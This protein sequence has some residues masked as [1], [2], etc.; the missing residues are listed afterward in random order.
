MVSRPL[1]PGPAAPSRTSA[2]Y[3]DTSAATKLVLAEAESA[4]LRAWCDRSRSTGGRIVISDL[5][6][7]ELL[8][9]V[10]RHDPDLLPLADRTAAR[11]DRLRLT[12]DDFDRA[13]AIE[14]PALRTLDALHLAAALQLGAALA[15]VVTYG[16][17]LAEAADLRGVARTA[18][19]RDR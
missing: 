10:G 11:F 17:R 13:T 2:W 19:G 4:A 6:R 7:A 12:R 14:P 9:A 3:L 18:P 15:G 1:E 16:V 8:R 5:V